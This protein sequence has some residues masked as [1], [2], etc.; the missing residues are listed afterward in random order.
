MPAHLGAVALVATLVGVLFL[1][2]PILTDD[3]TYWALASDFHERGWR[4]LR[5]G[6]F[7]DL[8]WPV[9]GMCWLLQFFLRGLISYWGAAIFYLVGGALIAFAI[10][11]LF[12]RSL[13]AAWTCSIAFLFHPFVDPVSFCPMPDLAEGVWG[14]VAV[15]AWWKL[16]QP[17]DAKGSWLLAALLGVCIFI[18]EANRVTGLFL[19]P[20]LVLGTLLF[21]RERFG[22]L[23]AAGI[24][25]LIFYAAECAF[26][27]YVFGDWLHDLTANARNKGAKGT[28]FRNPWLLPFRFLDSFWEQ[29]LI[30][31]YSLLALAGIYFAARSREIWPR[32]LVLWFAFLFFEYSCAPQS[33]SPIRPLL[34]DAPRFLCS[35]AVPMSLLAVFGLRDLLALVRQIPVLN[36]LHSLGI[37]AVALVLLFATTQ[38]RFFNLGFVLEF[39][40]YLATVPDGAVVFSH[41]S[42]RDIVKLV[43]PRAEA[44]LRWLTPG[45]ILKHDPEHEALAAQA[46]EFWYERNLTWLVA[47]QELERK[48]T[49]AHP[50]LAS[51]FVA[52]EKNWMLM[53]ALN[54]NRTPDL[55]FYRKRA[56]GSAA[57]ED[58]SNPSG[59]IPP[60]PKV[61]ERGR[62]PKRPKAIWEIPPEFRG[63]LVRLEFDAA[64]GEV[65]AFSARLSFFDEK[66][67]QKTPLLLRPC[68]TADGGMDFF[69]LQIPP[70]STRC[71]IQLRLSDMT[72][73]VEFTR[74]RVTK[75]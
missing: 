52:P 41:A 15:W 57:P 25:A 32:F 55:I 7:Y 21:F 66:G 39:R 47:R 54:K 1:R 36:R 58:F 63:R 73:R 5:E 10:G 22:W 3:L 72:E 6:S 43:D 12:T 35:L 46:D 2:E 71:E 62:S 27:H 33:L 75:Y 34:R 31:I 19:V 4:A 51:Y 23:L 38:R 69:D 44:R 17:R 16:M 26:Y 18:L 53:R 48:Q 30:R 65:D 50:Q 45:E 14:A 20:V 68:L 24:I 61:W 56:A 40:A 29:P 59:I 64:A 28:E 8:R 49:S 42:M 74:V 9:W 67:K 13:A 60:L 11:N 70:N 37:Y